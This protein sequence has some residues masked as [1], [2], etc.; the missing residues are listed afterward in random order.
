MKIKFIT[1]EGLLKA[2]ANFKSIYKEMLVKPQKSIQELFEDDR[3]I[4]DTSMEIEDF[5]LDMSSD[6][7]VSTDVENIRRVYILMVEQVSMYRLVIKSIM[8]VL[9]I[10]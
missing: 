3:I 7:P 5:S 2:K 1:E 4:R 10:R 8:Y 6:N 9:R